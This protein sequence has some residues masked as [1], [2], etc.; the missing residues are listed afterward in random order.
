MRN[1]GPGR[2]SPEGWHRWCELALAWPEDSER[3]ASDDEF[4][5]M[6]GLALTVRRNGFYYGLSGICADPIEGLFRLDPQNAVELY[7]HNAGKIL[8]G[9]NSQRQPEA[10]TFFR[11]TGERTVWLPKKAEITRVGGGHV[12]RL[13]FDNFQASVAVRI[14]SEHEAELRAEILE[15]NGVEPVIF[16]FFPGGTAKLFDDGR[17]VQTDRARITAN[18]L[19]NL[20]TGL[21]LYNPYTDKFQTKAKPNRAWVEM[22]QGDVVLLRIDV[23]ETH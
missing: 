13:T 22:K 18:V 5:F 6:D 10:G 9:D 15:A 19:L 7:H 3:P 16:N 14:V 4:S 1:R 12:V 2:F 23:G 11:K 8:L 17:G 20:E 21:K